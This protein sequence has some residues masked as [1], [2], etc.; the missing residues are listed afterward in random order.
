M[1]EICFAT[2][3]AHKLEEIQHLLGNT[4]TVKGL[5]D[6]GCHED[7]PEEQDT[8]E[9]NSS[10]KAVYIWEKYGVNCFAD[11]TGLE[12]NA[13]NGEPGVYSARYAGP[14]RNS[15][16]N[17]GLLLERLAS[18]NDRSAQ[19]K[20]VI[21]LIIDGKKVQFEG[22]AK[23]TILTKQTGCDG[24][25]YDPIFLPEGHQKSFAEMD[26]SEKNAISHRGK[27]VQKLIRHLQSL[28]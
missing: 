8:I 28:G 20:T 1:K 10:Q 16:D 5:K 11:D 3:N 4:F 2:N 9:G 7:V 18:K 27:A 25:G 22:I 23:G 21:T 14:Q 24:F 12:V 13:L 15:D 6:I 19:F 17:M 26:M